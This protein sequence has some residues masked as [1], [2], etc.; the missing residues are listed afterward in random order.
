MPIN[1]NHLFEELDG[2]KCSIVEKNTTPARVE[3]LKKLLEHNGY[4]VVATAT[5]A[6]KVAPA[7]PAPKPAP[8]ASNVEGVE[9]P[10]AAAPVTPV[11]PA[12][13]PTPA[14]ETFTVGVTD[15]IFNPTNAIFGRLLRTPDRHVVTLAYWQQKEEVAHDD[16]PYYENKA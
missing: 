9:A 14:P 1:Q 8:A 15:L 2:V 3:F 5:P 6:P 4:T 10:I 11:T 16:I 7:R 12:T 13:P